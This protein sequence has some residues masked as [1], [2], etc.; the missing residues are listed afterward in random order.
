MYKIKFYPTR[1]GNYPVR[2]FIQQMDKKSRAKI[3]RYIE[4]LE[5]HGPNLLRPYADY[6]RDKIGELRIRLQVGNVRIFY[7]FFLEGNLI[8]LHAFKK[9]TPELPEREIEQAKK[10][11]E[12]FILRYHQGEFEL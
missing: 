10:N 5:K 1:R 6:V 2:N 4:L 11:M 8:L 7:F 9:K 12:D 3:W